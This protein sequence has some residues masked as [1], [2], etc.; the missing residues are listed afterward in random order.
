LPVL[1]L[2]VRAAWESEREAIDSEGRW[3]LYLQRYAALL[4]RNA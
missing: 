3:P 1:E 2:D 4:A